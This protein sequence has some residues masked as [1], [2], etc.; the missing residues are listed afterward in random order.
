MLVIYSTPT[1][2]VLFQQIE[3]NLQMLQVQDHKLQMQQAEYRAGIEQSVGRIA[4]NLS[5]M[6]NERESLINAAKETTS[7]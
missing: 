3:K 7:E 1:R 6:V 5:A 4:A 2:G